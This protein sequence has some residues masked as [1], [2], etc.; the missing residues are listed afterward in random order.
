[1]RGVYGDMGVSLRVI[2][3]GLNYYSVSQVNTKHGAEYRSLG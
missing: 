2:E 1:M 3:V